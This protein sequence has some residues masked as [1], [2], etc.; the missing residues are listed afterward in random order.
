MAE[1]VFGLGTSH[2]PMLSLEPE[3]WDIRT[4]AD[5]AEPAHPHHGNTYSYDELLEFR[6][7]ETYSKLNE[8]PV[9]KEHYARCQAGLDGLADRINEAD[10][11]VLVIFG[12]DQ[13]EWFQ[14]DVQPAFSVYFGETVF[15]RGFDPNGSYDMPEPMIPVRSNYRPITDTDYPV[16]AEL[17]SRIIAQAMD[18]EIDV[19]TS[20]TPPRDGDGPI[21]LGHAYAFV[22][23]RI[24]RDRMIP[25]VPVLINTYYPPNQPTAKRCFDLGRS[26]AR[27]ITA[28]E[29]DCRVGVVASGG[30]TH[31]VIDEELD[32]RLL[33]AMQKGDAEAL[34]AE[35][36]HT[37]LS[38]TSEIKNWIAAA[39]ALSETGLSMELL[40]YVPC[41][42][43]EAGTGTA[44]AFAT[45]R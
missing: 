18:D 34:F 44:M 12:D 8:L 26:V 23:R 33:D 19:S 1:I 2:S 38:G 39:G 5:K 30:L 10:P 40:D 15:G 35:P 25:F 41:Y 36:A 31:F 43:S 20:E 22:Y 28:W 27:A 7:T 45:W 21:S 3:H 17:V 42:R 16:E 32:R 9:R 13:K 37:Y 14:E 11:D 24:L 29:H 6:P 4:A